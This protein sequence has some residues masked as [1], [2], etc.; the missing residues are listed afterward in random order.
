MRP[1]V[2]VVASYGQTFDEAAV[3]AGLLELNPLFHFD[4]I[5]NSGQWHPDIE[6]CQGV[7]LDGR[8]ICT[9]DR[10]QIEEW[11]VWTMEKECL[12]I[13]DYQIRPGEIALHLPCPNCKGKIWIGIPPV[14][15]D[16]CDGQGSNGFSHVIRQVRDKC[17]K[18]GWQHTFKRIIDFPVR[19][20]TREAVERQFRI[21]LCR[22]E[23]LD[24]RE[25]MDARQEAAPIVLEG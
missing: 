19:G 16:K 3:K 2:E 8:H 6:A 22:D 7:F 23:D 24:A 5:G 1:V 21:T 11:P 9:M 10:G 14:M 13:P 15:C 4:L 20:C 12:E 18:V 17:V 25:V